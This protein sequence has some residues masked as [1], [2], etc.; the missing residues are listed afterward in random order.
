[1][2]LEDIIGKIIEP[3]IEGN[4]L[5]LLSEHYHNLH[6]IVLDA[7]ELSLMAITTSFLALGVV[8]LSAKQ[9]EYR[10][11]CYEKKLRYFGGYRREHKF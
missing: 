7:N 2:S 10:Q 8:Y 3:R 5:Y 6:G 11:K 9:Q 4:T 1:M